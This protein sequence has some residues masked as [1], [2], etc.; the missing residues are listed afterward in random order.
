M[1]T[2]LE[3]Q[4]TGRMVYGEACKATVRSVDY[5]CKGSYHDIIIT[6]NHDGYND[7]TTFSYGGCNDVMIRREL[8]YAPTLNPVVSLTT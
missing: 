8:G 1:G 3:R 6:S 5:R 4:T 2:F 7:N